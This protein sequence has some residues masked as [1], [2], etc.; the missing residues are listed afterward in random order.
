MMNNLCVNFVIVI[1]R[2]VI[3]KILIVLVVISL[4]PLV[5]DLF[6]GVLLTSILLL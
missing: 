4:T 1:V 5:M 2:H 6:V 3:E